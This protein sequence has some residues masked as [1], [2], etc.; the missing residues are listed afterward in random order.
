MQATCAGRKEKHLWKSNWSFVF[1]WLG[2]KEANRCWSDNLEPRTTRS[3]ALKTFILFVF[4]SMNC[5]SWINQDVLFLSFIDLF[6][7]TGVFIWGVRLV[8]RKWLKALGREKSGDTSE[9]EFLRVTVEIDT[10]LPKFCTSMA[11]LVLLP[12]T[13]SVDLCFVLGLPQHRE[14][15]FHGNWEAFD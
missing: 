12:V 7:T 1:E 11:F 2:L 5:R 4:R 13:G 8:D 6:I 3:R 14:L 10:A 15:I 9:I